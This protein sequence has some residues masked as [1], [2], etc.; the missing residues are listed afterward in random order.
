[1]RTRLEAEGEAVASN[2]RYVE[3]LIAESMLADAN[4]LARQLSGEWQHAAEPIRHPDPRAATR[5]AGVW[6][7]A[8]P[9]SFV[10]RPG[11][12]YISGLAE[13]SL[14]DAFA[15]IGSTRL[16]TGPVKLAGGLRG[17]HHTPSGRRPLRSHQHA[18]RPRVRLRGRVPPAMPHRRGPWRRDHRRHRPRSHRQGRDFR[19]AEMAY[20]D[21][22]GIYHMVS[23]PREDWH[24][25]PEVLPGHDSVN[26]T[27]ETEEALERA[28]Y[29]IAGCSG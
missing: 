4:A 16:H 20:G 2:P 27:S 23:I 19:L 3:W 7:T 12:S 10:T 11:E 15:Q 28:G 18:G 17:W 6:F 25:L 13:P 1:M 22:P 21:Y 29:I 5:R 14:W 9:L 8:Y 24:L 26:L